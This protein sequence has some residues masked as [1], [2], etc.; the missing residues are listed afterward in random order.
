MDFLCFLGFEERCFLGDIGR[1]V[2]YEKY[3]AEFSS[4]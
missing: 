4:F 1:G 2:S 3:M